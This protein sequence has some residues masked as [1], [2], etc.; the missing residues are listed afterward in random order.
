MGNKDFGYDIDVVTRMAEDVSMVLDKGVDVCLT[1]GG[2]NICRGSTISELGIERVT[3]DFMG[4]L[5]TVMN[6]ISMQSIMETKF[7][8]D[9]RVMSSIAM[10]SV[11]EVYVCRKALNH[12]KRGKLVI[13]AAGIGSPFFTTD[14]CAVLRALEM[15][16]DAVFKGTSVDGVYSADPKHNPDAIR[17]DKVSYQDILAKQLR[18]MDPSAVALARDNKMS[19]VVFSVRKDRHPLFKAICEDGKHTE[20]SE[21]SEI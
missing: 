4:M 8:K 1:I 20:I 10:K 7:G 12:M 9:T 15:K 5:A 18:I 13:F 21:E 17:Y 11:C 19:I 16:C 6:A 3:G 14:T 2:G